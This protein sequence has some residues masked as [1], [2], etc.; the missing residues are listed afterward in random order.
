M[1]W[2]SGTEIFDAVAK[3]LLDDKPVDKKATLIAVIDALEDGDWDCQSE[4]EFWEHPIVR[5]I[6]QE[7][8]PSWFEDDA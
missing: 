8:H 3:V 2:C 7:R 6:M 4:S 5:E 1:G